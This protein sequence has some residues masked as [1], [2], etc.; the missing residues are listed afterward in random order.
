MSEI[1]IKETDWRGKALLQLHDGRVVAYWKG[2]ILVYHPA[3]QSKSRIHL[4]MPFLKKCLCKWRMTERLLHMDVRWAVE[5][6]ADNLLFL[7]EDG[8]FCASIMDGKLQRETC[9]FRGKPFSVCLYKDKLL[10]GDYGLNQDHLPVNIHCRESDGQWKILYT[11]PAVTV[12]HIHNI[13]PSGD[14]VCIMSRMLR[15]NP[16]GCTASRETKSYR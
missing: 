10:F 14:R 12:L 7:F 2:Q 6:D 8:V 13:I 3:N 16:I 1:T 4:P 15:P 11:F 5:T 9:V